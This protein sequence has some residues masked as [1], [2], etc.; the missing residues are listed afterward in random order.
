MEQA[1]ESKRMCSF[2][3]NRV[4]FGR[5]LRV[6]ESLSTRCFFRGDGAQDETLSVYFFAFSTFC[7]NF[8][9]KL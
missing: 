5:K 2:G 4:F 9:R 6:P 1:R 7:R 3:E 8:A